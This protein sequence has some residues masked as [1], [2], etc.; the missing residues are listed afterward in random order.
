MKMMKTVAVVG[1]DNPSNNRDASVRLAAFVGT[2]ILLQPEQVCVHQHLRPSRLLPLQ[3]G[4][5]KK[6]FELDV[7]DVD[8]A[9]MDQLVLAVTR[10]YAGPA[11]QDRRHNRGQ[12]RDEGGKPPACQ[13]VEALAFTSPRRCLSLKMLM[14]RS[15]PDE[16][17]TSLHADSKLKSCVLP[18]LPRRACAAPPPEVPERRI[19]FS[20]L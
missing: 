19:S 9:P 2:R 7:E 8:L 13:R 10:G 16:R 3:P 11:G 14:K 5:R 4:S 20:N 15:D 17:N 6:A 12:R 18:A 1:V